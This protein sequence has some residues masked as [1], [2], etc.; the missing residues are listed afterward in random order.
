MSSNPVVN[1]WERLPDE[2]VVFILRYLPQRDLVKVSLINKKFCDVSRD[3]SLWTRL[4]L[5]FNDIKESENSCK[6]LIDRYKR[7]TSLE[8]TNNSHNLG[9]LN[10]MSVVI[11]AQ[12]TLKSLKVDSSIYRWPNAAFHK[13]SQMKELKRIKLTYT[14]NIP[15]PF[16]EVQLLSN[17]D[18]LEEL[19]VCVRTNFCDSRIIATAV[20]FLSTALYEFKKLKKVDLEIEDSTLTTGD[21]EASDNDDDGPNPELFL[22]FRRKRPGPWEAVN[23]DGYN[24]QPLMTRD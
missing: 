3:S 23:G 24:F 17:L 18:Q 6:Q 9:L 13:L 22:H 10:F 14:R 5:D 12:N 7:L 8:I 21:G 1:H 16:D 20:K 11:R 2:V 15:N 19:H 4:I